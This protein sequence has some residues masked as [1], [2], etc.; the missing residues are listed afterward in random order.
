MHIALILLQQLGFEFS[1][2]WSTVDPFAGPK[3]H[4]NKQAYYRTDGEH[5]ER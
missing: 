5:D 3:Y 1:K 4:G 2:G